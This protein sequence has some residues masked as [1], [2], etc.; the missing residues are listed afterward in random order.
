MVWL[1]L[2]HMTWSNVNKMA[3]PIPRGILGVKVKVTSVHKTM[4]KNTN[5]FFVFQDSIPDV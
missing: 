2:S 4:R 1:S 5:S 3:A